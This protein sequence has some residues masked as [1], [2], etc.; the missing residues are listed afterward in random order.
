MIPEKMFSLRNKISR[1]V[2]GPGTLVIRELTLNPLGFSPLWIE[3][4]SGHMWE[5]QVLLTD[6]QVVS[7]GSP[8]FND[9]LDISDFFQS[10]VK[11]KLKN[12]NV[13]KCTQISLQNR[14][15]TSKSSRGRAVTNVVRTMPD[16]V[17]II[18]AIKYA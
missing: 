15:I 17:A 8:V 18:E 13:R 12:R 11:S 4:R 6:G 3:P 14:A 9:R 5:S 2:A 16:P 1:N 7:P 10:A